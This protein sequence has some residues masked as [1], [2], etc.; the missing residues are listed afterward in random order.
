MELAKRTDSELVFLGILTVETNEKSSACDA[1]ANPEA[2]VHNALQGHIKEAVNA[3]I[4]AEG[5]IR[6]G[7]P[8]SELMKFLASSSSVQTIVWGGIEDLIEGGAR[9]KKAHWLIKTKSM[10]ECPV[11][12]PSM[13][14]NTVEEHM[15]R[16]QRHNYNSPEEEKK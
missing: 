13:K 1:P 8:Q 9:Q 6:I 16:T 7:D 11:V 5:E 15:L 12:V 10:L 2:Q 14:L 3:G 4:A